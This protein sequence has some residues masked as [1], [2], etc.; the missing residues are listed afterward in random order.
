MP[1][2]VTDCTACGRTVG[3]QLGHNTRSGAPRLWRVARHSER[4]REGHERV[5]ICRGSGW[6]VAREAI[7]DTA[8][9][10]ATA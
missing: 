6:S 10:V 5:P 4:E 2:S 9:R 7:R 8:P 3:V 1:I